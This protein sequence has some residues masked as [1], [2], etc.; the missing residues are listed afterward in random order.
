M[1]NPPALTLRRRSDQLFASAERA[2]PYDIESA[3]L[4]LFYAAECGLKAA[5]MLQNNLKNTSEVRGGAKSARSYGHDLRSL[6]HALNISRMTIKP[7][8]L[9]TVSRTGSSGDVT[10]LHEAWRYGEKI[11]DTNAVCEWLT[12]IVEW[13]RNNR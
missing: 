1:I 6:I 2:R 13:C 5:Y 7:H 4:L 3:A 8:P 11:H 10:I 9:I 12:S